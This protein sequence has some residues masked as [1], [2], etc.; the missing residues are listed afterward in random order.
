M[1]SESACQVSRRWDGVVSFYAR[2][3][4]VVYV[5]RGGFGKGSEKGTE[6]VHQIL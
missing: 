5:T 4:G 3:W 2:L 1:F 6:S